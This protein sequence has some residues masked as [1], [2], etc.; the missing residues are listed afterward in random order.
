MK[1]GAITE[2]DVLTAFNI[3]QNG[4][5]SVDFYKYDFIATNEISAERAII[6]QQ[7]FEQLSKESKELIMLIVTA[8]AEMFEML[9]TPKTKRL[10]QR[11]IRIYISQLFKSE[12]IADHIISEI[13]EW[14]NQ[15]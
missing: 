6:K 8:P 14:V 3:L 15:L 9:K 7:E 1:D 13:K 2:S 10:T 11:S 4:I 5:Q 12:W